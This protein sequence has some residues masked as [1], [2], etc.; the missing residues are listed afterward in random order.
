MASFCFCKHLSNFHSAVL[1]Q[2]LA[3]QEFVFFVVVFNDCTERENRNFTITTFLTYVK[4]DTISSNNLARI[5][6]LPVKRLKKIYFNLFNSWFC[7]WPKLFSTNPN[8]TLSVIWGSIYSY[9]WVSFRLQTNSLAKFQ[10]FSLCANI[11]C[12][13]HSRNSY[14][15]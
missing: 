5:V 14:S 2:A 6:I 13:S 11:H 10:L 7:P 3:C 12:S 15:N 1:M 8:K 9:L 4:I